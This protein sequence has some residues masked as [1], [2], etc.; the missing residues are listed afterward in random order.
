MVEC[1]RKVQKDTGKYLDA[2]I[3]KLRVAFTI[4]NKSSYKWKNIQGN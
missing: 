2:D 3:S 1:L 4:R